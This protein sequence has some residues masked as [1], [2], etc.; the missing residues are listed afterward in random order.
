MK[1]YGRLI[2]VLALALALAACRQGGPPAPTQEVIQ[3]FVISADSDSLATTF[4]VSYNDNELTFVGLSADDN[5]TYYATGSQAGLVR[6]AKVSLEPNT[7]ELT[8]V[9]TSADEQV[10]APTLVTTGF[11]GSLQVLDDMPKLRG[12]SPRAEDFVATQVAVPNDFR[13]EA[14]FA[15]SPLGDFDND[16]IFEFADVVAILNIY[17]ENTDVNSVSDYQIYHSDINCDGD[18]GFSDVIA[19]LNKFLGNTATTIQV[20]PTSVNVDGNPGSGVVLIGNLGPDPLPT[21]TPNYEAGDPTIFGAPTGTFGQAFEA[22]SNTPLGTYNVNFNAGAAGNATVPVLVTDSTANT[23]PTISAIDDQ[24]INEDQQTNA[25]E[26]TIGDIQTPPDQLVVNAFSSDTT[27]IPN[28]ALTLGGAGANR[29]LIVD[30]AA[31]QFTTG[32]PVTVTV[33]VQD[34]GGLLV[35]ETFD[36]TVNPVNDPPTFLN[37]GNQSLI[38]GTNTQQTV[39]NWAFNIDLGPNETTQTVAGFDV[40]VASGGAL[41]TT[42]PAV[43]SN[44]TLTYTPSG[45]DGVATINVSLRDSG[46]VGNGGS[47]T[48]ATQQ[49]TVTVSDNTPPTI[50]PIPNQTINEDSNTGVINFNVGDPEDGRVTGGLAGL[51]VTA[52]SSNTAI[53]PPSGIVLGPSPI[54]GASR[55]INIT[56]AAD[57][58]GGPVVIT[59]IVE[60][61]RGATA[62]SSFQVNVNPVNDAPDFDLPVAT[63]IAAFTGYPEQVIPGFLQNFDPGPANESSQTRI[64]TIVTNI[65]SGLFA[66]PPTIDET[67]TLRFTPGSNPGTATLSVRVRDSGGTANGGVDLSAAQTFTINVTANTVPAGTIPDV[68][69]RADDPNRTIN[70]LTSFS[71]P[72]QEDATLNFAVSSVT[73]SGIVNVTASNLTDELTLDFVADGNAVVTVTATDDGGATGSITF[74]VMVNTPPTAGTIP[75]IVVNEGAPNRVIDLDTIF[76]NTDPLT[77]SVTQNTNTNVVNASVSGSNLTLDFGIGGTSTITVQALEPGGETATVTFNV[78]VNAT[79][80][81]ISTITNIVANVNDPD[82]TREL[83]TRFDDPDD[84]TL[85]YVITQNS[86]SNV[87]AVTL[88]NG[89]EANSQL[90]LDFLTPGVSQVTLQAVDSN[91]LTANI[92]FSVTVVDNIPTLDM[93]IPNIT[94]NERDE[95]SINLD[96]FFSDVE[97]DGMNRP[98]TFSVTNNTNLSI[99]STDINGTFLNLEFLQGGIAELTVTATDSQGQSVST[100]FFVTVNGN[101]VI[102]RTLNDLIRN[103][104]DLPFRINLTEFFSDA[105]DGG[106][107]TYTVIGNT[108]SNIVATSVGGVNLN[109]NPGADIDEG[110]TT[111]ITLRATDTNGLFVEQ[112]FVVTILNQPPT[113]R[114]NIG[115]RSA[116]AG[117]TTTINLRL[118]FTDIGDLSFRVIGNTNTTV[119]TNNIGSNVPASDVLT[120]NVAPGASTGQTANITVE[121]RDAGDLTAQQTF[122][123]TVQ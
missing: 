24:T 122:T 76:T 29:T 66:V 2:A 49:F 62:Q 47:D 32:T 44:G 78:R 53:I 108:N 86:F 3:G 39:P 58:F 70:L 6:V 81:V 45:N 5:R 41:F 118:Y 43:G 107:L 112:E 11:N 1:Q 69:A 100:S 19:A 80:T 113:I 4:D 71:D 33:S 31:N 77:Y 40:V 97:D 88:E 7:T 82:L 99:V 95:E 101:P 42:P 51:T 9:F 114:D 83:S 13:L 109:L 15:N 25:L 93:V 94:G 23:T 84:P 105:E 57:Q 119:V 67:G 75:D 26:F 87:V 89:A 27:V 55:T 38:S 17:L 106:A 96:D 30:P 56:P 98:L 54:T 18:I 64:D 28:N 8:L 72:D 73:P 60:D 85:T 103:Q 123:V 65:P 91:G 102:L 37:A 10:S 79:P 34:A 115:D 120:I 50:T 63:S 104:E 12:V 121:A 61:S 16:Q 46:G 52:N 48:S 92:S 111:T 59:V 68:M 74:Q 36:V 22:D 110:G 20:C 35:E 117:G 90:R 116:P 21:V 14:A